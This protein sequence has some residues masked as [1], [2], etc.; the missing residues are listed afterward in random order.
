M[1]AMHAAA[2][3]WLLAALAHGALPPRPD[4][5]ARGL[6][7]VYEDDF[8]WP[9]NERV[10]NKLDGYVQT[11]WDIVCYQADEAYTERGNLVLRTRRRDVVCG[12]KTFGY[13]SGW[14]DTLDKLSLR[15]GRIELSARLPAPAFRNWPAAWAISERNR[16]DTGG[17]CWPLS[18][19]VDVYEAAAGAPAAS[20]LQDNAVCGSCVHRRAGARARGRTSQLCR[21]PLLLTLHLRPRNTPLPRGL[22]LAPGLGPYQPFIFF[23]SPFHRHLFFSLLLAGTTG[24]PRALSTAARGARAAA[25][26]RSCRT[27][28]ASTR[29]P[30]SGTRTARSAGGT[31]VLRSFKST[32]RRTPTRRCRRPTG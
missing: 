13:S 4:L 20:G 32:A 18:T 28:T 7:L 6:H 5:S 2:A 12:G 23:P 3:L 9:L 11:P 16:R 19:E 30:P 8:D 24:A 27:T 14:V 29:T 17:L 26:T 21:A 10:W 31:T 22:G 1:R 25:A 15:N